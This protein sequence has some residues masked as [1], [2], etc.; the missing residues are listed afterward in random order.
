MTEK[1]II[2]GVDVSE[3]RYLFDDTSYKRSKTSCSITLKDCKY[4]GNNCYFKQLKRK[5]R[6]CK[7]QKQGLEYYVEKTTQLLDDIDNLNRFNTELQEK[8]EELEQAL[9]KIEHEV[10][11]VVDNRECYELRDADRCER[12]LSIINKAKDSK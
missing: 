5:E 11:W 1:I 7:N 9:D 12:I 10:K 6:E 8:I 4:L 3:C 2:D